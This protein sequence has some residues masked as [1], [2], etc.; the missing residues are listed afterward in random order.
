MPIRFNHRTNSW[1]GTF[2]VVN[3]YGLPTGIRD[4]DN[5]AGNTVTFPHSF[6]AN[7]ATHGVSFVG[8]IVPHDTKVT[9][10]YLSGC[11]PVP[12]A[13]STVTI[14]CNGLITFS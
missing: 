6:Q 13:F 4:Y 2:I 1:S 14:D 5:S 9:I 8:P 7:V 10:S 3:R 11:T 12:T